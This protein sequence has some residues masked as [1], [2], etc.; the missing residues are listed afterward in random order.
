MTAT[1]KALHGTLAFHLMIL[2][3]LVFVLIFNYIPM[4]GIVI[5][6]KNY[7]PGLGIIESPWVGL[8]HFKRMFLTNETIRAFGN[9]LIIAFMKIV[10]N[11]VVPIVFALLLNEVARR[12]YKRVVQTITYL[13]HFLSWVVLSGIFI[14]LLS[15]T[16]GYVNRVIQSLGFQPIYFLGDK[17]VFRLTMV[18]TDVWK[19]FGYN[20]IIY[21]AALTS[22]DPTLYE[23]AAVDGAGYWKRTIHITLPG[24]ANFVVLMTILGVGQIL[25]AGFD[26]IFNMYNV[27]VYETGD[28]L[29]TMVY[30]TG[31]QL[32]QYSF[33]TAVGL[34][35]SVV[36]LILITTCN[37]MANVYAGYRVF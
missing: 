26:Q 37:K 24:I 7:K 34:F 22:I 33:S 11:L 18:V 13:P 8:L 17:N 35:R 27:S 14:D 30:R 12:R 29:D 3:P 4:S 31:I 1:R 9:T 5:A 15:P 10:A 16:G 6:F 25:N 20:T 36:G 19:N 21:L 32:Q 28:I 2:I 23:V